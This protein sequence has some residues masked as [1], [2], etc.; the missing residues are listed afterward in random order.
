MT[1]ML[2]LEAFADA[3]REAEAYLADADPALA[4]VLAGQGPLPA[5]PYR[6]E[7]FAA[8]LRALIG[9]QLSTRAAATIGGRLLALTGEPPTPQ[10]V[11]AQDAAA[12][13]A[14]G[15]STAK[16]RSVQAAARA[17][18]EGAL[19][20]PA[21]A[22]AHEGEVIAALTALP[23]V[24]PWTAHMVL[25]FGLG[26]LDVFAPADLGLRRAIQR[27]DGLDG[28]PSPAASLERAER[29]RPYRTVAAWQLW[30]SL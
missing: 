14:C 3:L 8:L 27:L 2:T 16:V 19:D 12:L 6:Q 1:M 5:Q 17:V 28:L 22:A 20:L 29:W 21:L 24:G 13:R 15:L 4:A 7:P 11:L 10:A 25:M 23:G 18:Q 26:R 9:Q 30:R